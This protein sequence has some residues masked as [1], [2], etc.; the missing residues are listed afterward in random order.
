MKVLHFYRTYFPDT[1]GGLEE[2][3]R[4]M[5]IGTREF[6]VENRVLTLSP[7]PEPAV[8]RL[9]EAEVTRTR[10]DLDIASCSMSRGSFAAFRR[11]AD[12]ADVLHFHFPWPF[13]DLVKLITKPGK[14]SLV[15]YHSD[16]V[17]QQWLGKVYAPLMRNFLGSASA[18]VA[19]S[20][21]YAATSPVLRRYQK[22]LE[23][24]PL[25]IDEHSYPEINE[26]DLLDARSRYG[27]DFYL[28]IG[29][30]RP[31]KGLHI[32]LEAVRDAP[33]P[34][35]IVGAGPV[36]AELRR[37]AQ[38]QNI[39]NV[40]FTGYLPDRVKVALLKLARGLV[41]PSHQR[42]E[43]FGM[44]LLEGAMMGKP[45]ISTEIGTGTSFVNI[46]GE[47]GIVVPPN[48]SAALRNAMDLLYADP[49]KA[50]RM[51]QNARLRYENCFTV[52][53]MGGAYANLYDR[54][55]RAPIVAAKDL[56]IGLSDTI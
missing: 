22:K 6:G 17:R 35:L 45:L 32:L 27:Q 40:H 18:I 41:F 51:G 23:I 11:L 21:N 34:V 5:C 53:D 7:Q 26:R 10:L 14:P 54:I 46:D 24:I 31:Y 8:L 50:R 16:I 56:D 25:A 2:A 38:R 15:T 36:E 12:W 3:I 44:S 4:Q 55:A 9:P 20:P 28:F 33:Y 48:N 43:A 39:G 52:S 30:L 29:V 47:T 1:Q 49:D 13:A 42:S 37:Q 19:T